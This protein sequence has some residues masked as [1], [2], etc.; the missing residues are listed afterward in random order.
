VLISE[1]P[2]TGDDRMAATPPSTFGPAKKRRKKAAVKR[3][4]VS[5]EVRKAYEDDMRE[6]DKREREH[7]QFLPD[8]M[9]GKR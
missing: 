6:R 7:L 1:V 2:R 8:D 4:V 3:I 5:D 9:K